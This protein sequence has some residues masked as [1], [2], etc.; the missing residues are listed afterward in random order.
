ME[1]NNLVKNYHSSNTF[2]LNT[3]IWPQISSLLG[4]SSITQVDSEKGSLASR[5]KRFKQD[6]IRSNGE[7]GSYIVVFWSGRLFFADAW[8]IRLPKRIR[9]IKIRA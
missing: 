9:N 8:R 3:Q 6:N 5:R 4:T 2:S 1:E 7:E